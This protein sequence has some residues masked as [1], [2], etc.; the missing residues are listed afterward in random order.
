MGTQ[1]RSKEIPNTK[2][3]ICKELKLNVS[4]KRVPKFDVRTPQKVERKNSWHKNENQMA[5]TKTATKLLQPENVI[6]LKNSVDHWRE[7]Q[8]DLQA[9]T[10]VHTRSKQF[11]ESTDSHCVICKNCNAV[12]EFAAPEDPLFH[13]NISV[14]MRTQQLISP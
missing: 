2:L 11:W 10:H 14:T 7:L 3:M 13:Q 4:R 9:G 12:E 5:N 6:P 1:H 8:N